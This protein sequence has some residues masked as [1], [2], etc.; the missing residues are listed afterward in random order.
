[1]SSTP[2]AA[3]HAATLS[4]AIWNWAATKDLV[5]FGENLAKGVARYPEKAKERFL[6]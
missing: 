4:S 6:S 1:M 2:G 3:N 5:A